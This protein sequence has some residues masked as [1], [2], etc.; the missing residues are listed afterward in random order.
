MPTTSRTYTRKALAEELGVGI[1]ALRFYEKL[2]LIPSP[3]RNASGYRI[4]TQDDADN[5]RHLIE[6]KEYGFTLKEIKRVFDGAG[7]DGLSIDAVKPILRTK[8]EEIND[9]IR[10]LEK[11]KSL[12]E[13]F[14]KSSEEMP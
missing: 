12:I 9:K 5:I 7:K 11:A 4:Y 13:D 6:A 2:K 8:I 3:Q 1:E 14:L 10:G